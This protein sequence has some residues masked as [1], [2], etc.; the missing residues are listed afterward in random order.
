MPST[1]STT[2]SPTT[3]DRPANRSPTPMIQT[4]IKTVIPTPVKTLHTKYGQSVWLDHIQRC[5]IRSGELYRLIAVEGIRGVVFNPAILQKAIAD[6]TDY[7]TQLSALSTNRDL[8]VDSDAIELYEQLAIAD[9]QA[10]ANILTP[11][12]QKINRQDGYVSLEVSPY[13]AYDGEQTLQE[14]RRLWAEVNRPNLMLKVPATAAGIPVIQQLISEGINVHA[15]LLFSQETYLQVAEAFLTGLE[16]YAKAGGDI[17]H[18]ASVA[19]FSM[20][21]ID[22]AVD[23]LLERKI[24]TAGDR[25]TVSLLEY[26]QGKIAISH[27]KL[28]Y[29][30][31]VKLCCSKRWEPLAKQ[32]AQ[33]QRLLWASTATKNPLYS[34]VLYVEELIGPDTINTAPLSTLSAFLE[35]GKARISLAEDVESAAVVIGSLAQMGIDFQA[36]TDQLLNQ[37]VQTFQ[38]TFDQLLQAIKAKVYHF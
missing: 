6:T 24:A 32:G 16:T 13:L 17:S 23:A 1:S 19:S 31:Y 20:S 30:E 33:P 21:Q 36:V 37:G 25:T 4:A 10:A 26:L 29:R 9:I 22:T 11:L 35:H 8:D 14:A 38:Q 12:Y 7:N 27:A 2:T 3:T 34:D 18:V 15:T 5:M 28:V